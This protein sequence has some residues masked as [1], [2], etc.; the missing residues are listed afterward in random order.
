MPSRLLVFLI[1]CLLY[2]TFVFGQ[3]Y[4]PGLLVT[5]KGDTL[6][7]EVEN[8]FWVEPP[9]F[10]RFR[11][12]A[13]SPSQ[14][15]QPRQL[16]AVSFT[17]GRYFRYEAVTFDHAAETHLDRLIRG[18]S[19]NF[20]TD[21]LLAEVLVDGPASLLRV[22]M[23]S[24]VHY[25]MRTPGHAQLALCERRFLRESS[26]GAW[27]IIDGN[28]YR[29]QLMLYLLDCPA[30]SATAENASFSVDMLV[31]KVQAYNQTCSSFH[32]PGRNW[33]AQ[34]NLRRRLALQGGILAGGRYN[35]ISSPS[36]Y[37]DGTCTDCQIRPFGGLYAE[38][39]QPSRIAA[40]Y[41]ELSLSTFHNQS[42]QQVSYTQTGPNGS[43]LPTYSYF[44]YQG[45]LS[46]ARLGLRFFYVLPHEQEILFGL[47]FEWNTIWHP[48]QSVTSGPAAIF[49]DEL[50]KFASTTLLPHLGLGWRKKRLTLNLDGQLYH[51]N[52]EESGLAKLFFGSDFSTRFS[53]SYRLGGNPDVKR[54]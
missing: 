15:F 6:R 39:F 52:H 7:G 41:G 13:E 33:L 28:N 12:T 42:A 26:N 44:S 23:S 21:S 10:I 37:L 51:S 54:R 50:L 38:L 2:T 32:Q 40:V 11:T 36:V 16:R 8:S 35:R 29:S 48:T 14:L 31:A 53:T 1:G 4:E 24:T 47:G 5:S 17:D 30:A 19:T 20:Q 34:A 25:L 18:N 22:A 46:T 3:A 49:S 43:Y 45:L 9:T 27:S